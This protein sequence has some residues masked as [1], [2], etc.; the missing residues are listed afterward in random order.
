[1]NVDQR[2]LGRRLLRQRFG[3]RQCSGAFRTPHP[4]PPY[5]SPSL[6]NKDPICDVVGGS[7]DRV[8][9]ELCLRAKIFRARTVSANALE[10]A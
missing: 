7:R 9:G 1:M 6:V 3:V 4:K 10:K 5:L 8:Q 2:A